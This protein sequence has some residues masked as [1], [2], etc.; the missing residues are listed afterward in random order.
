MTMETPRRSTPPAGRPDHGST[1]ERL[2]L[3]CAVIVTA[4]LVAGNLM[5]FFPFQQ[6]NRPRR[7]DAQALSSVQQSR[8]SHRRCFGAIKAMSVKADCLMRVR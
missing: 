2:E 4:G 6:D 7:A 5:L 1:V 8:H 3:V